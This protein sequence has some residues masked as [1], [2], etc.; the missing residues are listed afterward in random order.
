MIEARRTCSGRHT[1]L[2]R[3]WPLRWW[4]LIPLLTLYAVM[5]LHPYDWRYPGGI[6]NGAIALETGWDFSAAGVV[7]AGPPLGEVGAFTGETLGVL[8]EV[9]P[10]S[11]DQSGP[12]RILT[13]SRD[14]FSRNLTI[15]QD[16]G[17]LVVRLRTE[18]TDRNG[19]Q[20]G[21]P[22]ARLAGVFEAD[23]WVTIE[24][25]LQ[26]GLLTLAIDGEQRFATAL[27]A[28]VLGT[29][30]RRFELALGNELSCDR[31]WLGRI[32]KAVITGPG[33]SADYIAAGQ[34]PEQCRV[35]RHPPKLVP[36]HALDRIDAF[37][38]TL[39]YLPLG[40][41]LG[42]LVSR[43]SRL[44]FGVLVLAA[45]GVSIGFE[46]AQLFLVSRFPSIDDVLFNTLGGAIGILIGFPIAAIAGRW[47][48]MHHPAA[49]PGRA[50]IRRTRWRR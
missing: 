3:L 30:N 38:N 34:A 33:G 1:P 21:R 24:L 49:D 47:L 41:L 18:W 45:A 7:V 28:T 36:L 35:T 40:C 19:L 25:R 20:D 50:S 29:W 2:E 32:R 31:P 46:T 27:P 16:N 6:D 10:R 8:L 17:D 42:L 13:I 14:A 39:M 11:G 15:A 44:T 37:R 26:P 9:R 43:R 5:S 48:A 22:I 4:V 23:R 12:A